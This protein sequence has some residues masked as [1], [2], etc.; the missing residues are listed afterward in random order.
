ML[1]LE[2]AAV[3]A[4]LPSSLEQ[5][6]T[7]VVQALGVDKDAAANKPHWLVIMGM[8]KHPLFY[9]MKIEFIYSN[10]Y[11][12][13]LNPIKERVALN[14]AAAAKKAMETYW[15]M[16]G[17]KIEGYLRSLTGLKFREEKI[18][19]FLNSQASFSC[20]LSLKIEDHEDMRANLVHELIHVLMTQNYDLIKKKIEKFHDDYSGYNFVTRIHVL[21][22]AIHIIL[23]QKIHPLMTERTMNYSVDQDYKKSWDIVRNEGA[24]SIVTRVFGSRRK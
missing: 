19:C 2:L 12:E 6:V 7:T 16:H 24:D 3:N 10:L 23:Q 11:E 4:A 20:P 21:V 1:A 15:N 18:Q 22:H 8:V 13:N 9:F 5:A 14:V 17:E